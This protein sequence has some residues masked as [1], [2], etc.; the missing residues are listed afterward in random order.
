MWACGVGSNLWVL[1]IAGQ[2]KL[3]FCQSE[4]GRAIIRLPYT[5]PSVT[6]CCRF[7]AVGDSSGS[8]P[9][10]PILP[11][12]GK[13]RLQAGDGAAASFLSFN[14]GLTAGRAADRR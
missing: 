13:A 11:L 7:F 1:L 8:A 5:S 3:L 10:Q 9:S 2:S 12:L 6:L 14:D 4:L